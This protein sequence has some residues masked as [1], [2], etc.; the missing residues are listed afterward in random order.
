MVSGE[1]C[2]S[3]SPRWQALVSF[4][5]TVFA[6]FRELLPHLDSGRSRWDDLR[7]A[8]AL[9]VH[10]HTTMQTLIIN[11]PKQ[12]QCQRMHLWWSSHRD[13]PNYQKS[14]PA[15][16]HSSSS[17]LPYPSLCCITP[18]LKASAITLEFIQTL[19]SAA[20]SLW[21]LSLSQIVWQQAEP[22][23]P[24]FYSV[25][26][27]Q[28]CEVKKLRNL[29]FCYFFSCSKMKHQQLWRPPHPLYCIML[30]FFSTSFFCDIVQSS[31][32]MKY[33]QRWNQI[34]Y[35]PIRW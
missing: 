25:G 30:L 24:F 6:L 11:L 15:S 26:T 17:F 18:H 27:H 29:F 12:W 31:Q 28:L 33:M 2:H 23:S 9:M 16:S 20:F 13:P 35:F 7:G 32:L 5:T 3:L 22:L 1:C 10:L 14:A 34:T 19:L 4:S 21:W 8:Q